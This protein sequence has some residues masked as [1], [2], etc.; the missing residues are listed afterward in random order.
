[1]EYDYNNWQDAISNQG[2]CL[3][4]ELF[5]LVKEVYT[6]PDVGGGVQELQTTSR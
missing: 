1:M 5:L 4:K 6:T 2:T 3:N